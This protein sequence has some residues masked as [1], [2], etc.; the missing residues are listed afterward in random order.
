MIYQKKTIVQLLCISIVVVFVAVSLSGCT[1]DQPGINNE[2]K[3]IGAWSGTMQMSL[4]G[5]ENVSVSQVAFNDSDVELT[6]ESERGTYSMSYAYTING[7]TLMLQPSGFG[8]G[9]G[10][11]GGFPGNGT[12]PRDGQWNGTRPPTNGTWPPNGTRPNGSWQPNGTRPGNGTRF[13]GGGRQQLSFEYS[14]NEDYTVLYLNGVQFVK[15]Q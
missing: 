3:L 2:N 7:V 4:F 12:Y 14:F 15:I 10:F 13:P 11:P 6:M 8:R 1:T 5:R 9:G